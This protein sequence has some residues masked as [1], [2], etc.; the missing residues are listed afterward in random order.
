M[1]SIPNYKNIYGF[2]LMIEHRTHNC[3]SFS[4]GAVSYQRLD[5]I[6]AI[7]ILFTSARKIEFL[8]YRSDC[9]CFWVVICHQLGLG[10]PLSSIIFI[11]CWCYYFIV[12]F[13]IS[14]LIK[15]HLFSV[16]TFWRIYSFIYFKKYWYLY[17]LFLC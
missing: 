8:A 6:T 2:W 7:F 16:T 14:V 11:S 3:I 9:L 12:L 15:N 13:I 1:G 5:M 10:C 17:F 4:V